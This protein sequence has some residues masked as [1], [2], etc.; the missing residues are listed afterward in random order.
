MSIRDKYTVNNVMAYI[1][2]GRGLEL[3]GDVDAMVN[4]AGSQVHGIGPEYNLVS[5]SHELAYWSN[6]SASLDG[7]AGVVKF[8]TERTQKHRMAVRDH[9]FLMAQACRG[10][11]ESTS[12]VLTSYER[13]AK[14]TEADKRGQF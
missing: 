1:D 7:L 9:L 5:I 12:R 11:Y 8:H 10:K 2:G 6:L 3:I 4:G 14:D 13:L